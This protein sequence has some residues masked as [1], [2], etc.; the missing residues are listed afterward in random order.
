[1]VFG[2]SAG[3]SSSLDLNNLDGTNGF[4]ING[5]A[6]GDSLGFSVSGIGDVN[7]DGVDDLIVG[8]PQPPLLGLRVKR[9]KPM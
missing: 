6:T 4:A 2:S 1:M 5:V 7:N 3:F 8:A 9:V